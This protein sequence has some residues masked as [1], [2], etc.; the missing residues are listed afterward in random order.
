MSWRNLTEDCPDCTAGKVKQIIN[1]Q[2]SYVSDCCSCQGTG[3]RSVGRLKMLGYLGA[4]GSQYY[5]DLTIKMKLEL[6]KSIIGS[7]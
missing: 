2:E 7:K 4:V 3:Q 5:E 6:L 1:N